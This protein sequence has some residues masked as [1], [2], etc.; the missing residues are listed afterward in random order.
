MDNRFIHDI[1]PLFK[2]Y[3]Q[4]RLK[5]VFMY[6]TD[7][8]LLNCKQCLYRPNIMFQMGKGEIPLKT[9]LALLSDFR[10]L[11]AIKLTFIGGEPSLYGIEQDNRPLMDLISGSRDL[12]YTYVRMDTNGQ[13]DPSFLN[14][15]EIMLL[16][17]ISFSL[18]GHTKEI[19]DLLRGDGA[20][21]K[22]V[23]NIKRVVDMR[24]SVN[25]TTC[26]HRKL[27]EK[28][29][30]EY[31]LHHMI[32]FAESLRVR[33][34]NFHVL[35][36]PGFPMDTW[37]EETDIPWHMWVDVYK[38]ILNNVQSGAYSIEVRL[39]QRFVD[40]EEFKKNPKYYAYCPVKLGERILAH[41]DS[42]LRICSGLISSQYGV[43]RFFDNKIVWDHSGTNELRDHK[44]GEYT[45]CTNQSKK[46]NCGN[47]LPLCF[48]FKAQQNEVVWDK[49][50]KWERR[51][52]ET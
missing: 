42:I 2:N 20:Y 26:V 25:I 5:Q 24:Q 29:D 9:A 36:K 10:Q 35:F 44:L 4:G 38:T 27:V 7:H 32:K 51:K 28:E 39:P 15:P 23:D 18:D 48:S 50:L 21:E 1:D 34:I 12:G 8:C 45:P 37:T 33:Q 49:H 17:E 6:I 3:F 47:L 14:H 13:F 52:N 16:N 40:P 46:M 31:Q 30:G 22:C 43:A 11:G 41:P 19:H